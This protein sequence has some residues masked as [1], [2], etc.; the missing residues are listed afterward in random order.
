LEDRQAGL[1]IRGL[2]VG[3]EPP[4]EA[5]S[6][7]LLKSRDL[8]RGPVGADDDLAGR[9]EGVEGVEELLLRALLAFEEL[10]VVHQE[11]VGGPEAPVEPGDGAALE[12]GDE[13]V[14]E[15]FGGDVA[16]D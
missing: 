9:V 14:H 12:G 15:L 4:F 1:E 13:L 16:G 2:D 8:L 7:T 11:D 3:G 5:G 10:D 6:K